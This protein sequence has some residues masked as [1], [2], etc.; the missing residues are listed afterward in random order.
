MKIKFKKNSSSKVDCVYNKIR[1]NERKMYFEFYFT[2]AYIFKKKRLFSKKMLLR[3]L[4]Y[5]KLCIFETTLKKKYSVFFPLGCYKY[6]IKETPFVVHFLYLRN[7]YMSLGH[8]I[9]IIYKIN[10]Y[11]ETLYGEW[12]FSVSLWSFYIGK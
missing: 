5:S 8:Y 6:L 10:V 1:K 9:D 11:K 4:W 3:F 2:I 12:S 7:I